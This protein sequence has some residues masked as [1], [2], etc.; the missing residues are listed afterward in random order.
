V[1]YYR[2][3]AGAPHRS[4]ARRVIVGLVETLPEL[5]ALSESWAALSD[6]AGARHYTQPFWCLAWWRHFGDGDLHVLT[7]QSNGRLLALAPLRRIRRFGVDI[8]TFFGGELGPVMEILV[9]PG[10]DQAAEELWANLMGHG[11]WV[12]DLP[13]HR[14]HGSALRVLRRMEDS[15]CA[16][17]LG[18]A[19]PTVRTSDSWDEFLKGRDGNLRR[20][21]RR[22]KQAA[23]REGLTL[24]VEIGERPEDVSRLLPDVDHV[25]EI[26]EKEHPRLHFLAGELRAFTIEILLEAARAGHLAL[27]VVYAGERPVATAFGFRSAEVLCYSGPRFDSAFSQLSPGHLVLAALIEHAHHIGVAEVDLLLGDTRYKREWSTGSYDTVNIEAASSSLLHLAAMAERTAKQS[28]RL[29]TWRQSIQTRLTG[30]S[31]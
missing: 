23:E 11:R 7:V 22:A 8:L 24:R 31:R 6:A 25:Y 30:V 17:T 4:G 9:A 1:A 21:L 29:H 5:E 19:C 12:L 15:S 14:L 26:A 20:K 16:M 28:D 13:N 27:V 2:G 10:E 3:D 18:A